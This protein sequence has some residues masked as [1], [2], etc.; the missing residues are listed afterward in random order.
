[1]SILA[2]YVW[3][4]FQSVYFRTLIFCYCRI[5]IRD[6]GFF[7]GYNGNN[8]NNV[9]NNNNNTK[10]LNLQCVFCMVIC[11]VIV[12]IVCY[13]IH[14]LCIVSIVELKKTLHKV[15]TNSTI[16]TIDKIKE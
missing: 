16:E 2:H 14:F 9:K 13:C 12:F 1:M 5:A 10:K 15:S 8:N 4:V 6:N 7:F 11:F 3:K